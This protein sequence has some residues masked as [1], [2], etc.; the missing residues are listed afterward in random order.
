[1]NAEDLQKLLEQFKSDE[2]SAEDAAAR[3]KN[4]AYE[5][6][7]FARVDHG[8]ASRQG[9]PEVIFGQGK[10]SEQICG[11]FEKLL[12]RSPN[13][14]ITRTDADI[15]GDVRNIFTDAEWHESA[16]VIRVLR[17]SEG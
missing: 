14:L 11:I 15:Y 1:M 6:I 16:K 10:T 8:R 2:L 9:F 5:D 13:V 4:L 12:A 17:R 7:G 3:N